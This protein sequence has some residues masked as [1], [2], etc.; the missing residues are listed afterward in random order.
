MDLRGLELN[1]PFSS[2]AMLSCGEADSL[3]LQVISRNCIDI[4]ACKRVRSPKKIFRVALLTISVFHGSRET[5]FDVVRIRRISR[6]HGLWRSG[7]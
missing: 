1:Q 5:V 3:P 2:T 7:I 4:A 6:R